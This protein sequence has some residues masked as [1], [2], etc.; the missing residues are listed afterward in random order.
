[1]MTAT[2]ANPWINIVPVGVACQ[3]GSPLNIGT[4]TSI[5]TAGGSGFQNNGNG[6]YQAN[7][8]TMKSWAGSCANV[9]VTFSTGSSVANGV[10]FPANLGFQFN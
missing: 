10:V 3:S 7:W 5:S 9:Q 8:K 4:D 1:V 2:P 6:A